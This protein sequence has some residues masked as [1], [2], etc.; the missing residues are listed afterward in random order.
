MIA[1]DNVSITFGQMISYGLGA[2]LADVPNGWRYMVAVGGVPPIILTLLLPTCPESPRQLLSHDKV[3]EATLVVRKVF[4]HAT[5]E[6][7]LSKV[8]NIRW[9]VHQEKYSMTDKTLWWQFKQLHSVPENLRA[10][11]CACA[12]MAISQLGGFNTLMYY[13]ATLF[14]LVGFDK[15][16][17]VSIVV[18]ATN[19]VFTFLNMTVIDKMGRRRILLITVIGM[20][21]TS[22]QLTYHLSQALTRNSPSLCR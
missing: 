6:Q 20:V 22:T 14:A 19:F 13:S 18:G 1:L 17:A 3:E 10:L 2:G 7:V 8:E 15:P 4:P 21:R 12:V 5:D 16:T 11:I 9:T